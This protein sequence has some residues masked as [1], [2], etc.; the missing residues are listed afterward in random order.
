MDK[1]QPVVLRQKTRLERI[2]ITQEHYDRI[3]SEFLS[4]YEKRKLDVDTWAVKVEAGIIGTTDP[5]IWMSGKIFRE[6]CI[7]AWINS[8]VMKYATSDEVY[9]AACQIVREMRV[10]SRDKRNHSIN[11]SLLEKPDWE[12]K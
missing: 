12:K 1:K 4:F 2:S 10:F 8:V 9:K 11:I 3:E 6:S 7:D 5:Y